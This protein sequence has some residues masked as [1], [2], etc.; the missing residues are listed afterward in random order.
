MRKLILI[1]TISLAMLGSVQAQ[2]THVLQAG[3]TTIKVSVPDGYVRT[4]DRLP[5]LFKLTEA[6]IP[7]ASRLVESFF[8]E[9]DIKQMLLG[10]TTKQAPNYQVHTLRAAEGMNF[11]DAEWAELRA[12]SIKEMGGLDAKQLMNSTASARDERIS[13]ASSGQIEMK[14]GDVSKPQLYGDDPE[15]IRFTMLVPFETR[16]GEENV[17]VNVE[18][19]A[20]IVRISSKFVMLYVYREHV[21]TNRLADL[22]ALL[23]GFIARTQAI[24]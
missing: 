14:V 17:R 10:K 13:S 4:S 15:S 5:D 6:A 21:D 2:Q 8:T 11:N 22:Q 24:Q 16:V 1:I 18:C 19:A 23:D 20:A 12:S 9:A 7:P 3:E